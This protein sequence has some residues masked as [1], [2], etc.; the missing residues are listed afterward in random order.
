MIHHEET[1]KVDLVKRHP[2]MPIYNYLMANLLVI[3]RNNADGLT[4]I[5]YHMRIH[6]GVFHEKL[7]ESPKALYGIRIKQLKPKQV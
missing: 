1:N 2:N 5:P 6:N 3:G 4:A 7:L